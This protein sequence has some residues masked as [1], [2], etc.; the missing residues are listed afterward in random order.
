[1]ML[2]RL[3]RCNYWNFGEYPLKDGRLQDP[4]VDHVLLGVARPPRPPESPKPPEQAIAATLCP[5]P[6]EI[7]ADPQTVVADLAYA[8]ALMLRGHSAAALASYRRLENC[9]AGTPEGQVAALRRDWLLY[10]SG[11]IA[12][13]E[14]LLT[15]HLTQLPAG[16]GTRTPVR[17]LHALVRSSRREL[18]PTDPD[19]VI[20]YVAAW[21]HLRRLDIEAARTTF[22]RLRTSP[23]SEVAEMSGQM[24]GFLEAEDWGGSKSAW[25]AGGLSAV[26]PG[27]GRVYTGRYGDAGFS[28]AVTAGST[29]LAARYARRGGTAGPWGFGL[30]AT[31]FYLANVYGSALSARSQGRAHDHSL[32]ATIGAGAEVDGMLP[33]QLVAR[34]LA[35]WLPQQVDLA[36]ACPQG[37]NWRHVADEARDDGQWAQAACAYQRLAFCAPTTAPDDSATFDL[38][39]CFERS[40]DDPGSQQAYERLLALHPSSPL[41]ERARL[42]L[43][44]LRLRRGQP[45]LAALELADQIEYGSHQGAVAEARYL[46][47]WVH[48][49]RG[50]W[51]SAR[52]HL[53]ARELNVAPY[54][55]GGGLLAAALAGR[56]TPHRSP[57][58]A[59]FLSA[60]VP[61]LGQAY[62]GRPANGLNALAVNAGFGL[63]L[64]RTAGSRDWVGSTLI[65]GLLSYRFYVGNIHNAASFA[66]EYNRQQEKRRGQELRDLV[67]AS[68]P[69][70]DPTYLH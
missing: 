54:D 57:N 55:L 53:L 16:A 5:T 25:L 1:M 44:R 14:S 11:E 43:A 48:L 38:A 27:L 69:L 32:V 3:T 49:D 65:A 56:Q 4:V 40:G 9:A 62:A 34:R 20:G 39:R 66:D 22:G 52:R 35:P 51:Q 12:A 24:A 31:G 23:D 28:F 37:V 63:F 13:A 19:P 8:D 47:T 17:L 30:S 50:D 58:R 6:P 42:A 59:R 70:L 10:H 33:D 18:P 46:L 41:A 15:V 36:T 68:D 64:A 45:D 60:L 2:D 29:A 26:V 67:R 61:G 7:C 21:T